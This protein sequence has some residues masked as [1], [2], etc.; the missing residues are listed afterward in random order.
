MLHI[1]N[2]YPIEPESLANTNNGDTVI[3]TDNAVYAIQENGLDANWL[4]RTFAHINLCARKA[5]L[6]LR[7]ISY[8]DLRNGVTILD[9]IDFQSVTTQEAAIRSWN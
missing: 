9:D 2:H 6:M 1:I 8:N 3:F 7:N 5:D 4:Q